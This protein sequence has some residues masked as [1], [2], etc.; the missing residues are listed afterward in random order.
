MP[1]N[2]R[3]RTVVVWL[4]ALLGVGATYA[5]DFGAKVSYKKD[6]P[7]P[8]GGFSLTFVGE[9]RVALEKYPRGFLYYDFRVTSPQGTQTISWTSGTGEIGPLLFKVG[10]EGFQLELRHSDKLGKLKENEMVVSRAP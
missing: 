4:V 2:I 1:T 5:A 9:R 10:N 7:V 6:A 8:F 3:F